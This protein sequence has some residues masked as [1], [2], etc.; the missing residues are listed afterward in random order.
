MQMTHIAKHV[1]SIKRENRTRLHLQSPYVP[2][3]SQHRG[4]IIIVL[5]FCFLSSVVVHLSL[6]FGKRW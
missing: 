4:Q 5:S 1:P 6:V 2:S 3:F